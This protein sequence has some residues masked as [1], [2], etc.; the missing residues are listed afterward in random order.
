VLNRSAKWL[1][2]IAVACMLWGFCVTAVFGGGVTLITHGLGGD[3]D[4]W[5]TAMGNRIREY[6]GYPATDSAFY[7]IYLTNQNGIHASV[8]KLSGGTFG[9]SAGGELILAL[10]WRGL[11][12]QTEAFFGNFSTYQV[13]SAVAPLLLDS[14]LISELQGHAVAEL[15]IHLIG[16][17]RGGSL[18]SE[19]S[20]QLGTRGIWVDHLTTLDPHPLNG[21]NFPLDWTLYST[22][23]A[24]ANTYENV[25]FHDNYFQNIGVALGQ[26]VSGAYVRQ[27]TNLMGGYEPSALVDVS[28]SHSDVHLWYHGTLDFRIPATDWM[29]LPIFGATLGVA[30]RQ[31]W[32]PPAEGYGVYAGFYYSRMGGGNRLSTNQPAGAGTSRIS[33]GY[34]QNWTFGAGLANNRVLLGEN[35]F[36]WPN[37][38]DFKLAGTNLLAFGQSNS[39]SVYLQ[40][41]Q[42]AGFSQTLG[43][44]LDDDFNPWNGNERLLL[45]IPLTIDAAHQISFGTLGFLLNATNSTIGTHSLLGKITGGG[46][47]RVMYAPETMTLF[48]SF[49]APR[50][51]LS[52][53]ALTV[54]GLAG[55]RITIESSSDLVSWQGFATNW[56]TTATWNY[57]DNRTATNS[58]FYRAVVR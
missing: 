50:I 22:V 24:P 23:D 13:A 56:L 53:G 5:V 9:A 46:R 47:T 21:A 40:K 52:A 10:D 57:I 32:W 19:L 54:A 37:I 42:H 7:A 3:I 11:A 25:L 15:P 49:A 14:T 17:S 16:H 41:S 36:D 39:V 6:P 44:F 18:I 28:S 8:R 51:R 48:S 58:R 55:Q 43:I 30:E 38:I 45:E 35:T 12:S 31:G 2:Q 34:N 27:L 26:P 20:W 4:E 29:S 1:W 33:D